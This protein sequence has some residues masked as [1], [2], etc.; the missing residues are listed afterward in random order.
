MFVL[1]WSIT[2]AGILG[3]I[4][5]RLVHN[6]PWRGYELVFVLDWSI[7]LEGILGRVCVRLVHNTGG[8]INKCLCYT[9]P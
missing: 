9:G 1:C 8:D 2:L 6:I 5:V 7:T 3:S 4:C